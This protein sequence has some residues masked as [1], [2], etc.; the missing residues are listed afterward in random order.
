M[1]SRGA[2]GLPA[3]TSAPMLA[4]LVKLLAILAGAYLLVALL[5]WRFQERLA[6]PGPRGDVPA[7]QAVGI[8][9]GEKVSVVTSDS[10]RLW[11]WY[12]PPN[13]R[14]LDGRKAPGL[15]WFYGNMETVGAIAPI[16]RDLRP[17][18]TGLL[19]L[20]YRGYGQSEGRPSEAGLYRDAEAAWRH[21]GSRPEI[22]GDKIGVY[23][24]SL[25]SA[26]AL[27][28][29]TSHPVRALV[30]DSPFS[31]AAEMAAEHY[32]FL[33]SFLVRMSLDN[34]GRAK[35]LEAPLLVFH[36][37]AD[38]IAPLAMGR[39]VADAG[40][41]RRLVVLDGA[42]HNETYDAGGGRYRATLHAFLA[43]TLGGVTQE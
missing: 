30:L 28:L 1:A 16:V 25:G 2:W 20:D 26:A 33:P 43:E 38:R 23:G 36:G 34:V 9:D 7:P 24:R 39:A 3:L 11:G 29:A 4:T 21:L 40:A 37:S 15:L 8:L 22:D 35:R 10:L 31:S 18:G 5:V 6:M 27:Y 14:P 19:V 32:R 12:L 13:P 17:P 42:G 41:A